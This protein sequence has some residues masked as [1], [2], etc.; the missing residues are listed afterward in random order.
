MGYFIK[1]YSCI[2]E[3]MKSM[4]QGLEK[5]IELAPMEA[6][7]FFNVAPKLFNGIQIR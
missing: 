2:V 3:L 7:A 6:E 4:S 1:K 5:R